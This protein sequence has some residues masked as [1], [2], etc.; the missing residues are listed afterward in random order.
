MLNLRISGTY[1]SISEFS[2]NDIP[3][4]AVITGANGAGK[5]QLLEVIAASL[6]ALHAN[7]SWNPQRADASFIQDHARAH[8][9]GASFTKQRVFHSYGEWWVGNGTST[10]SEVKEQIEQLQRQNDDGFWARFESR[11]GISRQEAKTLDI[12]KFFTFLLPDDVV[13]PS[14]GALAK[15]VATLFLAYRLFEREAISQGREPREFQDLYG[16]APWVRLNE[17]L[18]ASGLPYECVPPEPASAP[19]M[20]STTRYSPI[21]RDVE[22][23]TTV[24]LTSL[25][26][27]ENVIVSTVLWTYGAERFGQHY[28]LLLLD[29]PDAHL[30]PSLAGR[31]VEVLRRVF[32]AQRG[33]RVIL[34]THSPSTVAF[35]EDE[36]VFVMQRTEPRI[37]KADSK[38]DAVDVLTAGLISVGPGTRY[39]FVEDVDDASY[40]NAVFR[41]LVSPRTLPRPVLSGSPSVVFIHASMG[42]D[43][44]GKHAVMTWLRTLEGPQFFGIVD[45]DDEPPPKT[46]RVER[47]ARYE[48]ENYLFDPIVVAGALALSGGP[49]LAPIRHEEELLALDASKLQMVVD[50]CFA[51]VKPALAERQ[52]LERSAS[53][54]RTLVEYVSGHVLELPEWFIRN[55]GKR[56]IESYQKE[57]YKGL[58][59]SLLRRA[60]ER[61]SWVPVEMAQMIKRLQNS[62]HRPS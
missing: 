42:K 20:F 41:S 51:R 10:E 4:F 26:A 53:D 9:E 37:T 56:F 54:E 59:T 44:G 7:A 15:S 31:F 48:V 6:G 40:Y 46:S 30:H 22:R 57:I 61:L 45:G 12:A 17:I 19:S 24:P 2:W 38:W 62:G 33:T 58:E 47:P 52:L 35:T 18:A 23:N 49:A 27:G 21:L 39:I 36:S 1:G 34:T 8:F 60:M 29:E 5:T 25:S 11:T 32:V 3:P 55:K 13:R 28:E 14:A 43:S 16:L 50:D